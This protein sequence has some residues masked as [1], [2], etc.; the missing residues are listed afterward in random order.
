MYSG[1]GGDCWWVCYAG[2]IAFYPGFSSQRRSGFGRWDPGEIV[3]KVVLLFRSASEIRFCC[4]FLC[5]PLEIVRGICSDL[6]G[7]SGVKEG[8][9]ERNL[10]Y[11]KV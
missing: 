11:M 3:C 9:R 8:S 6:T 10:D 5:H 4:C 1:V 7:R 2:L